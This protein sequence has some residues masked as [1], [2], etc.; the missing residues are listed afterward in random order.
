MEN[1]DKG[2]ASNEDSAEV[3][4]IDVV[5]MKNRVVA[6]V[7]E[8]ADKRGRIAKKVAIKEATESRLTEWRVDEIDARRNKWA[9]GMTRAYYVER[10]VYWN[11]VAMQLEGWGLDVRRVDIDVWIGGWVKW[12]KGVNQAKLRKKLFVDGY[13]IGKQTQ[14]DAKKKQAKTAK[15]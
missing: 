2:I 9:S 12:G 13:G 7:T 8:L 15:K 14:K 3:E 1:V 4:V 10:L 11:E 5:D 6:R